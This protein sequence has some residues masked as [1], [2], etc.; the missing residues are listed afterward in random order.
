MID[1]DFT[2]HQFLLTAAGLDDILP[3]W[4]DVV[5]RMRDFH[6]RGNRTH[7]DYGVIPFVQETLLDV[8]RAGDVDLTV[9]SLASHIEDGEFNKKAIQTWNSRR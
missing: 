8:F 4:K 3:V 6:I 5:A 7:S 9:R 2:F 1:N